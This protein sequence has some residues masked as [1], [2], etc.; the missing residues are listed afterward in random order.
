MSI[1]HDPSDSYRYLVITITGARVNAGTTANVF[2]TLNNSEK[3]GQPRLLIDLEKP[4]FQRDQ[5]NAFIISYNE[6]IE[7][8]TDIRIWHNNKGTACKSF[9]TFKFHQNHQELS[10]QKNLRHNFDPQ[11]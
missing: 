2:C 9:N 1:L 7:N 10:K 8:I 3:K 4:A 6:P 5:I 11:T